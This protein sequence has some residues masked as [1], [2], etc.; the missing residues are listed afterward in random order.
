[1]IQRNTDAD[2]SEPE[3]YPEPNPETDDYPAEW[4]PKQRENWRN[5]AQDVY[6]ALETEAGRYWYR[7]TW[8]PKKQQEGLLQRDHVK[9]GTPEDYIAEHVSDTLS[10]MGDITSVMMRKV[11]HY[12]ADKE[13]MEEAI[14]DIV[15]AKIS[16]MSVGQRVNL[17]REAK[18][19]ANAYGLELP[20]DA[21]V[22]DGK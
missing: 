13:E 1:M 7:R 2:D 15:Q 3:P 4:T 6:E 22:D 14:D 11:A 16:C 10:P 17:A 20:S 12:K 8:R 19:L 21:E 9:L 5:H 18:R